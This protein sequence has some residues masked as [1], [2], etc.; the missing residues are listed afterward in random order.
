MTTSLAP[1]LWILWQR[2]LSIPSVMLTLFP[3][4]GVPRSPDPPR[5]Q[6]KTPMVHEV[7][8]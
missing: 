2:V 7:H 6:I 5:P 4:Q 1:S 8:T 3:N